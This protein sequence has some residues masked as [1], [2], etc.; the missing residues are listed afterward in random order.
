MEYKIMTFNL[1]NDGHQLERAEVIC[2]II[3]REKADLIGTQECSLPMVSY[4]KNH[5]K[6]YIILQDSRGKRHEDDNLILV[7]K[8]R[9]KILDHGIYSLSA[10][11]NVSGT[12]NFTSIQPR[13]LSYVKV[14][15]QKNI[16][17]FYNTHLDFLFPSAKKYQL[18]VIKKI[19]LQDENIEKVLVGDFNLTENKIFRQFKVEL[20]LKD[21]L[22]NDFGSSYKKINLKKSIDHILVNQDNKIIDFYKCDY[23]LNGIEA[24]DHY[25]IVVKIKK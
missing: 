21:A 10:K 19:L 13:K 25:P 17:S 11:E 6:D 16:F 2:Y 20:G 5:L 22:S 4:L 15:D 7:R 9:F 12:K 3:E 1:K 14:K 24:S 23:T 8:N 18:K